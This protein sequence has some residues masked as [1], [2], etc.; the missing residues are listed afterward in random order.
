M[1][2][3]RTVLNRGGIEVG[4]AAIWGPVIHRVSRAPVAPRSPLLGRTWG[5]LWF[6]VGA[7]SLL[8]LVPVQHF[9]LLVFLV[10]VLFT[11]PLL[12]V[13][14]QLL[15]VQRSLGTL[16]DCSIRLG[17]PSPLQQDNTFYFK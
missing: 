14:R 13:D 2:R 6:T 9:D 17:K 15:L 4:R 12:E 8:L 5:I 7:S 11:D 10:L 16:T 1:A 3:A